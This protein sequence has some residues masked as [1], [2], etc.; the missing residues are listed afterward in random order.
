MQRAGDQ[1]SVLALRGWSD[2][3]IVD[4]D[5]NV[6]DVLTQVWGEEN[7]GTQKTTVERHQQ[8]EVRVKVSPVPYS[9]DAREAYHQGWRTSAA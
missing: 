6:G 5:V 1:R 3:G 2:V 9:R 8:V 7:G 4:P